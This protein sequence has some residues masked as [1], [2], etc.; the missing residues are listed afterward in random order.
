MYIQDGY[1]NATTSTVWKDEKPFGNLI[2]KLDSG[3]GITKEITVQY[4]N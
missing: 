2:I 4:T 3:S 1:M